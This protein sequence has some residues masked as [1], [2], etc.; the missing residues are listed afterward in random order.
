[1]CNVSSNPLS[2]APPVQWATQAG[3]MQHTNLRQLVLNN[4]NV[5]W[6]TLYALL[7]MLPK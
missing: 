6:S 4:T 5:Q 2:G 3:R 1:M 7:D